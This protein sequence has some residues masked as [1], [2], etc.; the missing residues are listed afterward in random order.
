[1]DRV[2]ARE[3]RSHV[4]ADGGH[5][6][7]LP[8]VREGAEVRREDH[9]IHFEEGVVRHRGIWVEHGQPFKD[10]QPRPRNPALCQSLD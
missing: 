10:I 9:V 2:T 3:Y 6:A 7:M 4:A 8:F 5:H 1:M